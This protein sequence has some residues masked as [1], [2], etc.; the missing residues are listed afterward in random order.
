[1]NTLT[2]KDIRL[3]ALEP[4]DLDFLF[5]LENDE[6][7]WEISNTL[8]PFSKHILKRYLDN[9]HCDIFEAK[10]LRLIIALNDGTPIGCIDL[11]DFDPKHK[12]AGVGIIVS[13]EPDRQK[14]Y[15]FQA[16][17]LLTGYAFEHLG[18]HQLYA[19]IT[20]GN[21]R[22]IRLFEKAGFER[23]GIKMEWI[24]TSQGYKNELFYQLI[25][26]VH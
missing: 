25:R 10:Q 13:S 7:V 1:M 6:S 12:R 14:G 8:A 16:L 22:S 26:H 2:G 18:L 4:S 23:S 15:A 3:R 21:D 11:F 17:Q 24:H 20:Q 9:A 19:N 5:D